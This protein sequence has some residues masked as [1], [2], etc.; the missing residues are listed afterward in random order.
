MATES[1]G[2]D[3]RKA[4]GHKGALSHMR[5]S[6]AWAEESDWWEEGARLQ[7]REDRASRRRER[8]KRTE[9]KTERGLWSGSSKVTRGLDASV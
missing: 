6:Q 7:A 9:R 2:S 8:A 5:Q 4:V 1:G 3:I